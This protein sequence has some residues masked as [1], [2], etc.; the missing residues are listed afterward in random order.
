MRRKTQTDINEQ[1]RNGAA[2]YLALTLFFI[3][4]LLALWVIIAIARILVG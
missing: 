4:L 1:I 3:V 2:G